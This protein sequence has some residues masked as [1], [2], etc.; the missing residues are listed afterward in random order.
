MRQLKQ[1][2]RRFR[3]ASVNL[4]VATSTE[5]NYIPPFICSTVLSTSKTMGM[6]MKAVVATKLTRLSANPTQE[7]P[8]SAI[9]IKRLLNKLLVVIDAIAFCFMRV[10]ASLYRTCLFGLRKSLLQVTIPAPL[11]SKALVSERTSAIDAGRAYQ[12]ASLVV[13]GGAGLGNLPLRLAAV[14]TRILV[15][16]LLH[17]V[18]SYAEYITQAVSRKGL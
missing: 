12:C 8:S 1:R 5:S 18:T 3:E 2:W 13:A 6:G 14:G 16:T 17:V 7:V 4:L 10:R 11:S 9:S 15:V